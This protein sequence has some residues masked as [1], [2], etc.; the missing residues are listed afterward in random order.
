MTAARFD[1]IFRAYE[2]SPA[3]RTLMRSALDS[4]LPVE[5]EPYSLVTMEALE[6]I[7]AALR[8]TPGELLVDL[9]CGRGGPGMW[10]ARAAGARLLGVDFS[11]VAVAQAQAR[12]D[13]FQLAATVNFQVGEMHATGLDDALADGL[14]CVDSFQFATDPARVAGEALRVLRPGGRLVLTGWEPRAAE[15]GD[16]PA[17]IARLRFRD[18]LSAAGFV[19]IR[20]GE[21]ERWRLWERAL[22]QR[23]RATDPGDDPALRQLHEEAG[24]MLPLMPLLRRVIVAAIRPRR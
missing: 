21:R 23:A 9:A 4:R 14:M 3:I 19:D 13:M 1:D 8:L 2:K 22:F 5:V 17:T 15:A 20:V 18:L 6:E 7:V 11:P 16:L 24:R 12:I 10:A